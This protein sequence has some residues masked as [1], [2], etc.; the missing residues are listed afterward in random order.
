[1]TNLE[2]AEL[3]QAKALEIVNDESAKVTWDN[4]NPARAW[5]DAAYRIRNMPL[6]EL[7]DKL[8]K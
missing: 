2:I 7:L 6:L 5:I 8:T 3:I 1:M 4:K